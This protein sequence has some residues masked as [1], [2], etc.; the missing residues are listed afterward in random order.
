MNINDPVS[1]PR[2]KKLHGEF[3]IKFYRSS[4]QDI[5]DTWAQFMGAG[6]AICPQGAVAIHGIIQARE[7]GTIKQNDTV[8]AISTASALK[9]TD[10]GIAYHKTNGS[11]ANPVEVVGGSIE[12]LE[13]TL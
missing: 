7:N 6:A 1:F 10:A 3:D 5:V 4:E 13:A 2:I 9:F 11:F 8:V 12:A